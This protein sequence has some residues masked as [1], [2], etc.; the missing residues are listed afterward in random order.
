MRLD[1]F[2]QIVHTLLYGQMTLADIAVRVAA[3]GADGVD[4]AIEKDGLNTPKRLLELPIRRIMAENGLKVAASTPFYVR[5]GMDICH[6]DEKLRQETIEFSRRSI[7]VTAHAGCDRML[8]VPGI[9]SVNHR[10]HISREEDWK[11][12]VEALHILGEYAAGCGVMLMIEPINRY[13]TALVHT[14][15]EA[16]RMIRDIGLKNFFIVGDTFHMQM[17]EIEGIPVA[18]RKAGHHLQCL[19]IGDNTRRAPGYGVMDWKAIVAALF[20]IGFDG[21]LSYETL[22]TGFDADRV[23]RDAGY[24]NDMEEQLR[25]GMHY[26]RKMMYAGIQTRRI[27]NG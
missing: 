15:D 16:L 1:V 13:R 2:D 20:D 22:F 23:C 8:I 9:V 21:P 5:E 27:E 14:I 11:R 10:Y 3:V 25:F 4:L 7:D 26:L 19:H 17:E 24:I 12:A 18:L 6:T